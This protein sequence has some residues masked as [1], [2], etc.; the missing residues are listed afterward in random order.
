MRIKRASLLCQALALTGLLFTGTGSAQAALTGVMNDFAGPDMLANATFE[1]V[2]D[3]IHVTLTTVQE[4]GHHNTGRWTG[5][6]FNISDDDLLNGLSAVGD[7]V[8]MYDFSGDVYHVGRWL[9]N[10]WAYDSPGPMDAGIAFKR[11]RHAPE[12]MDTI[13]FTLSHPDGLTLDMFEDQLI[14]GRLKHVRNHCYCY[15]CPSKV[16]GVLQQDVTPDI[17][18]P[19]SLTLMGLAAGC[20]IR[21]R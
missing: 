17:P 3:D 1:Q 18:E 6:W 20:L 9:N 8:R 12:P 7:H 16:A 2:G 11:N 14:A 21:R 5:F 19:A 13:S 4:D 15:W 10:I